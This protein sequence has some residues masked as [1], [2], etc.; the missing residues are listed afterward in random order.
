MIASLTGTVR[1]VGLDRLVLD[2][3]GVGML[4]YTPPAV[5]AGCRTGAAVELATS[6]VVREDSLTLYGFDA[7]GVRDT[8]ELLQSVSG[9]GPRVA[10]AVVSVL[11]PDELASAIS[12]DD[13]RALTRVPGIGKKGAERLV[14]ELRDKIPSGTSQG[15]AVAAPARESWQRQVVDA[16]VGL[17]Y[18]VSQAEAALERASDQLGEDPEVSE[19]L[20]A[21]LRELA[22]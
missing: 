9:V 15:D 3:H 12:A 14:L 6:L 17:G 1:H 18:S 10:L 22:G 2:V 16:L 7:A 19:A 5:A 4:V 11:S 8:F 21:S 13:V 20:R